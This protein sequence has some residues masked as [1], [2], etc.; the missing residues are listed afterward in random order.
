MPAFY[1]G[2]FSGFFAGDDQFENYAEDDVI[3]FVGPENSV[4]FS[5]LWTDST[6]VEFY[7]RRDLEIA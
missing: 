7:Y 2:V 4:H 3:L 1:S 5:D 6:L